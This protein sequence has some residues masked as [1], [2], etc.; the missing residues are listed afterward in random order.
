MADRSCANQADGYRPPAH[1][2]VLAQIRQHIKIPIFANGDI[3]NLN[4][5]AKCRLDSQCDDLMIG[6]GAVI[7]PDFIRQLRGENIELGWAELL[8]WQLVFLDGMRNIEA[9]GHH[10]QFD[11]V[12][13]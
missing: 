2:H 3:C 11:E 9:N 7:R 13:V 10:Y 4:D 5:A 1:W 6:R 8:E 12:I